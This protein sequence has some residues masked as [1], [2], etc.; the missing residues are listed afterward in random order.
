MPVQA[1]SNKILALAPL[2]LCIFHLVPVELPYS[3]TR[4]VDA[5]AVVVPLLCISLPPLTLSTVQALAKESDIQNASATA[6]T[7]VCPVQADIHDTAPPERLVPVDETSSLR[8]PHPGDP[9]PAEEERHNFALSKDGA[10]I[11]A[12]N[13]EAKK[14]SAILDTDSDTFMKNE[15]KA[16]KWCIIELSQVNETSGDGPLLFSEP[17]VRVYAILLATAHC[18]ITL[19]HTFRT[20]CS[21][22]SRLL[23]LIHQMCICTKLRYA[24]QYTCVSQFAASSI[25]TGSTQNHVVHMMSNT[26][27]L[28]QVAK[29][30]AFQLSQYE[31]YSSRVKDFEVRGRQAHPRAQGGDYAKTFNNTG[32]PL[33]GK[34]TAAKMKGSQVPFLPYFLYSCSAVMQLPCS[35]GRQRRY[36]YVERSVW[37]G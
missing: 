31:L 3:F 26:P 24:G 14:A 4:L 25:F 13:K 19:K 18:K 22:A 17:P 11:I 7:T 36:T 10:K 2:H 29:V 5:R 12:S 21:V 9:S 20:N 15:C 1:M 16:D 6:D 33:L 27:A 8:Q 35:Q 37:L 30:E 34:Y 23:L 32:W 28:Y